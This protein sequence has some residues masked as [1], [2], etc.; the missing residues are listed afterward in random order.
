MKVAV[1]TGAK[2]GLGF[3]T[4]RQLAAKDMRVVLTARSLDVA[5]AA[6][7]KIEGVVPGELDVSNDASVDAFFER[8]AAE[9]GRCDVL[10]NN[11]GTIFDGDGGTALEVEPEVLLR[12]FDNNALGAYRCARRALPM[13]NRE[14]F[15]RI[16]NVSS[17]MGGLNDM[18]DG[19][20]AYRVSKTALNA[21]TVLLAHQARGDVKVNAICPG[22]V[23]TDMG[24]SSATRSIDESVPGIVWAAT[25]DGA[26]PSGGFF[27]DGER[28]DW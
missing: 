25:L 14:G 26:G 16:V 12:A 20:P 5:K 24:G 18:G 11:A 7:A 4:C 13:M 1:V 10:V 23:R 19:Y 21:I 22:W 3:E 15:G 2:G 17:G 8:L 9:H 6:A 28:I 27:R